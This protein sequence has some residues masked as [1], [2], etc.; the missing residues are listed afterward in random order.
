MEEAMVKTIRKVGNGHMIPLDKAIM[1]LLGLHDGDEVVLSVRDC[2][3]TV[4]PANIGLTD[5]ERE[6]AVARF[7]ARYDSVLQRLAK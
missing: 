1:E 2:T 5:A 3:L 7:R 6:D 4:T